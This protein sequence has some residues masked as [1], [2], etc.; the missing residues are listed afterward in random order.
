MKKNKSYSE[1]C[2]ISSFED[3]FKYL[4]LGG[5]VGEST[6]GYDR[7][8]NQILYHDS[9]WQSAR[10]RVILRDNGFDLGMGEYPINGTIYVHHLN[11]ITKKDILER[12]SC[13]FDPENL[14]CCSKRT[15][16]AIHY[17]DESLLA[18]VP[19]ERVR[20]DTCPWKRKGE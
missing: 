19:I 6:F 9:E 17:G 5:K 8:L 4:R 15:H 18:K 1:L 20:N 3:R 7:Y 16:D 2:M 13:L 10:Q 11:P 14:I 12:A